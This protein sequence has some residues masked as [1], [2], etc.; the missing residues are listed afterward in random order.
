MSCSRLKRAWTP[1]RTMRL[2]SARKTVMTPSAC[3]SG[4]V[5]LSPI[6]A[7]MPRVFACGERGCQPAPGPNPPDP[8][9]SDPPSPPVG[10]H[11]LGAVS[12][13][14]AV[15]ATAGVG[16]GRAQVEAGDGG[17]VAEPARHRP[18]DQLLVDGAR[19]GAE[20][21]ADQVG[22]LRGELGRRADVQ[23]GD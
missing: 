16:G 11:P 12:P 14:H 22:V 21:P 4:M 10:Q 15:H 18:E 5:L 2:S 23:P 9:R 8:H 6:Y 3:P 13:T 17:G 19:P 1:A 7:W 20:I